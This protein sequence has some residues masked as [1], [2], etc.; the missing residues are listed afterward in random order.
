MLVPGNGS[1]L[2][3]LQIAKDSPHSLRVVAVDYVESVVSVVLATRLADDN[4]IA[5]VPAFP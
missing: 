1:S 2:L 3:P 4:I 5:A